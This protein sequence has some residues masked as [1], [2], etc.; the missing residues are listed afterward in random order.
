MKC[1]LVIVACVI[2]AFAWEPWL[3]VRNDAQ[4]WMNRFEANV[5]NSQN[6]GANINVIFYGDS[7]IEGWTTVGAPLW[8]QHFT[9]L[10]AANYGI[11]GDLVQNLLWRV[12]NG[13]LSSPTLS[14]RLVV[15]KIGTNNIN[16][17]YSVEAEIA[18]GITT[19][20]QE[21]RRLLPQTRVLVLGVLP[22]TNPTWTDYVERI[23]TFASAVDDGVNVR[24]LNMRDAFFNTVTRTFNTEL[25]SSSDLLHLSFAGYVRWQ[26]V[27]NPLFQ[28]MMS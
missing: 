22:R 16:L 27:M 28:Q 26:E 4:W 20:V 14:P 24:F 15:L 1:L 13:E 10:G 17:A 23:N 19:V 3:P 5:L 11:G 6:N 25:Y 12:V 2:P 7:I 18:R 8:N 21:I 9:P